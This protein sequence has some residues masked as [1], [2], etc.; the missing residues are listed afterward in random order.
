MSQTSKLDANLNVLSDAPVLPRIGQNIALDWVAPEVSMVASVLERII[1]HCILCE[2]LQARKLHC[3][4][5]L[6][7]TIN[8][9]LLIVNISRRQSRNDRFLA[10]ALL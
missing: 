7:T 3:M 2:T 6:V 5:L 1:D 10:Q 8:R 4:S 9:I